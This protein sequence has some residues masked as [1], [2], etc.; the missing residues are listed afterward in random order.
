MGRYG[1]DGVSTDPITRT[2]KTPLMIAKELLFSAQEEIEIWLDTSESAHRI[3]ECYT[4]DT[5]PC[6]S[7]EIISKIQAFLRKEKYKGPS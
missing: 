1:I 6:S 3:E 7:H 2:K 5:P 4:K